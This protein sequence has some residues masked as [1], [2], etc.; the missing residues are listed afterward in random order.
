MVRH[1]GASNFTAERLAAALEVQ[2]AMGLPQFTVLQND[3]NLVERDYER[4]LLPVA[5]AWD[6]AALPYFALAKGFLTGKY[7]PGGEAVEPARAE[8]ARATST[9]GG[10]RCWRRSTRSRRPTRRR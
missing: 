4:T 5:E 1:I 2:R 9:A 7:R 3:Y 10:R 6:L 8:A